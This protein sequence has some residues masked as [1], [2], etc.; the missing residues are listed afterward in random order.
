L[1]WRAA[2]AEMRARF[3]PTI[4]LE[5][6]KGVPRS[7]IVFNLRG[8]SSISGFM[9]L[10]DWRPPRLAWRILE[11]ILVAECGHVLKPVRHQRIPS[12]L[13]RD[14]CK[15]TECMNSSSQISRINRQRVWLFCSSCLRP[16]RH[17]G[18]PRPDGVEV[19][20]AR[21]IEGDFGNRSIGHRLRTL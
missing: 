14:I 6:I 18:F 5:L 8:R 17:S 15:G 7:A 21:G 9:R 1:T 3:Q 19:Q 20:H 2:D 10:P 11:I 13:L 12:M 16:P 4:S